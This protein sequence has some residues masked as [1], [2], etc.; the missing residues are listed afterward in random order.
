MTKSFSQISSYLSSICKLTVH[1]RAVGGNEICAE[2]LVF[3]QSHANNGIS[4]E[5]GIQ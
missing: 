5:D 1:E 2:I 4:L 3:I